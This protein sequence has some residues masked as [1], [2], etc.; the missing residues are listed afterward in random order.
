MDVKTSNI[1]KQSGHE[2][3]F[4]I[5]SLPQTKGSDVF[6]LLS[7]L[8]NTNCMKKI[9]LTMSLTIMGAT[10]IYKNKNFQFL[11]SVL[12]VLMNFIFK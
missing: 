8:T 12:N 10:S 9:L 11:D 2:K 7:L 5:Y 6:G 4:V 3:V 1:Q